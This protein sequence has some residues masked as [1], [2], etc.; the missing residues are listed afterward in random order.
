MSST[1]TFSAHWDLSNNPCVTI[2]VHVGHLDDDWQVYADVEFVRRSGI[3]HE[4]WPSAKAV[5]ERLIDDL[6]MC[7]IAYFDNDVIEVRRKKQS[8]WGIAPDLVFYAMPE[9]I[10]D[11]SG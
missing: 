7:A 9:N 3:V 5:R 8:S 11:S 10:T 2:I 1:G 6:V 4:I